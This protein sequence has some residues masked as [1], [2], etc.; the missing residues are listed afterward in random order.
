MS[1]QITTGSRVTLHFTFT[2]SEGE[3]RLTT[4]GDE[5]AQI[6]IGGGNLSAS[7]EEHLLGQGPGDHEEI[8]LAAGE[9]FG[10]HAEERVQPL[11]REGFPADMELQ[12]G[13][14]IGFDTPE[15]ETAGLI[16]DLNDEQVIVDFNH[17][18]A[19]EALSFR[20]QIIDVSQLE[21]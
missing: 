16:V 7:I 4:L 6:I 5:P 15:G 8:Q 11:R 2:D 20:Y 21:A 17:P 3:V 19:G 13:L 9:A 12:T 10:E 1:Q 18:L 14:L